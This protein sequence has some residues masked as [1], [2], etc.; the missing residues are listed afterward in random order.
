MDELRTQCAA[1]PWR[2]M[3]WMVANYPDAVAAAEQGHDAWHCHVRMG[4][5][6]GPI[7]AGVLTHD[8]GEG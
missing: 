6:P 3:E 7:R 4:G 2:D 5:C 1:C 8:G